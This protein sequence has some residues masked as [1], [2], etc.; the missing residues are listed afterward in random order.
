MKTLRFDLKGLESGDT[1][2]ARLSGDSVNVQL[3]DHANYSAYKAGRR[4]SHARGSGHVTK[5]PHRIRVP[6]AGDWILA[7]DRGGYT[8][9]TD[10][11]VSVERGRRGLLPPAT[12]ATPP[13]LADVGRNLAIAR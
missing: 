4:F 11:K 9:S 2:V 8:V 1:V 10:V 5:S 13:S 3:L 7:V 6:R 12:S